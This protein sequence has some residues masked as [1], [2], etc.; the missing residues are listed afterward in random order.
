MLP[1]GKRSREQV[2]PKSTAAEGQTKKQKAIRM[3]DSDLDPNQTVG[4]LPMQV[5]LQAFD[6]LLRNALEGIKV[7][8]KNTK[9]EVKLLRKENEEL[10]NAVAKIHTEQLKDKQRI[11]LLE[12]RA[13]R[14]TL[15][16]KGLEVNTN[17]TDEVV[18]LCRQQLKL[19]DD[20]EILN[21]SKMYERAGKMTVATEFANMNS[22]ATILRA[23]VNL[24]DTSIT[25]D[26]E[27][28][29]AGKERRMAM[30]QL[31]Y[32]ILK[33]DKTKLLVLRGDQLKVGKEKKF[34]WKSDHLMCDGKDGKN[35]LCRIYNN[36]FSNIPFKFN[37]LVEK[38]RIGG[39]RL[40]AK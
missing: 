35:E 24:T 3:A 22:V 40:T 6:G 25:I 28:T 17:P 15:I 2:S 19:S 27:L 38:A 5:L 8:I 12:T 11:N 32:E 39:K 29:S 18:K 10:K 31:K 20:I 16:I 21:A 30:Q 34:Y 23:T 26:K 14:T 33:V 4:N 1:G 13:K 7:D 9:E 36:M 37:E